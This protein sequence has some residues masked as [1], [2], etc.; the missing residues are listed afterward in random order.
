VGANSRCLVSNSGGKAN[1]I[2]HARKRWGRLQ[3]PAHTLCT[4]QKADRPEAGRPFLVNRALRYVFA[5][6]RAAQCVVAQSTQ[7]NFM[8]CCV[9]RTLAACLTWGWDTVRSKTPNF[10]RGGWL[11]DTL[12]SDAAILIAIPPPSIQPSIF[13]TFPASPSL[14][15]YQ[16]LILIF[17]A[18]SRY[19]HFM[20]RSN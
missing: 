17:S 4:P 20:H 12:R 10:K 6:S 18:P 1:S 5:N 9:V 16:A 2:S 14:C 15:L 8:L 3:P 7:T 19:S 13:S 11:T